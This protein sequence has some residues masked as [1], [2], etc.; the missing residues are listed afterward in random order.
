MVEDFAET[1]AVR[2]KLESHP[3]CAPELNPVEYLWGHWKHHE[4]RICPKEFGQLSHRVIRTLRRMRRRPRLISAIL[5]TGGAVQMSLY[6]AGLHR[7]SGRY[8][9]MGSRRGMSATRFAT[10]VDIMAAF[11]VENH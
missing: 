7:L 10:D 6:Y 3:A 9:S 11:D 5:E 2:L 4:L 1:T 8:M